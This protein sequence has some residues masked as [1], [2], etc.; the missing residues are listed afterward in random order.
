MPLTGILLSTLKCKASTVTP[1]GL[2]S[3]GSFFCEQMIAR[4]GSSLIH[5]LHRLL[6]HQGRRQFQRGEGAMQLVVCLGYP[7][8]QNLAVLHQRHFWLCG[9][10]FLL[11]VSFSPVHNQEPNTNLKRVY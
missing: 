8:S 2:P 11:W 3:H 9:Q 6:D 5:W 7:L 10:L 4:V 1:Q